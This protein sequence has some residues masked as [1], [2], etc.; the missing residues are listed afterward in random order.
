M[1]KSLGFLRLKDS[2]LGVKFQRDSESE[3]LYS[4]SCKRPQ[5]RVALRFPSKVPVTKASLIA[6]EE[7]DTSKL[8]GEKVM[9]DWNSFPKAVKAS[10]WG[11][12]P[13]YRDEF[14][15]AKFD[16]NGEVV[17]GWNAENWMM[18]IAGGVKFSTRNA[19]TVTY[20]RGTRK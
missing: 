15:H 16:G 1:T 9:T 19:R 3:T 14:Y 11:N 8:K 6:E 13:A 17:P 5:A 10:V 7:S 2:T 20:P 18:G 12:A 4:L